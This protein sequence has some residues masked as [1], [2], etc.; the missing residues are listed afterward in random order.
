MAINLDHLLIQI[1][2]STIVIS[3]CL[4][5]AGKALV[6]KKAKLTDAIWIV[7]L[8]TAVGAIFGAY[9]YGILAAIVQLILWLLIVKHFFDTGWLKA[10]AISI[11]AIVI[12]A[13]VIAVLAVIGFGI[14]ALFS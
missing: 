7:I 13:V 2:I 1:V 11:I 14:W 5:L 9:F 6:G 8:G 10:L 4:W 3:P 12:F